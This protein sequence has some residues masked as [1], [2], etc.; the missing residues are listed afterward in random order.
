MYI[1][2]MSSLLNNTSQN[3]DSVELLYQQSESIFGTAGAL[4]YKNNW[5]IFPQEVEGRRPGNVLG[6]II[7][8]AEEHDLKNKLPTLKNLKLWELHCST[9]NAAC[10]F[11]PASKNTFAI[12]IDVLDENMSNEIAG[13]ADEILGY[14]PFRREGRVPKIA[15][16][17]RRP[18]GDE[19]RIPSTS[20]FFSK[21]D[22][23][24]DSIKSENGLEIL[25]DGKLL[26]FYGK[27]H[28]TGQYFK[29]LDKSPL[30]YG[31]EE[32]PIVT[33]EQVKDFLELVDATYRFHRGASF[34]AAAITWQ[35]DEES[36]MLVPEVSLAAG[37]TAWH[38]NIDGKVDDGREAYLSNLVYRTVLANLNELETAKKDDPNKSNAKSGLIF[39]YKKKIAIAV[40][41]SFETNVEMNSDWNRKLKDTAFYKVNS[42]VNKVIDGRLELKNE[43]SS[44]VNKVNITIPKTKKT[45]FEFEFF[46]KET[47]NLNIAASLSGQEEKEEDLQIPEDRSVLKNDIQMSLQVA[48]DDFFD[49]VYDIYRRRNGRVH[50]IKAPT[51]AGKTSQVIR[52]IANDP[53]TYQEVEYEDEKGNKKHERLPIVML[54]PTYNNID[55]LRQRAKNLNLNPNLSNED[56]KREALDLG[57]VLADEVD[58]KIEEIRRDALNCRELSYREANNKDGFVTMVYSGKIKAGCLVADKVSLAMSAGVGTSGFCKA[59]IPI[60]DESTKG[61]KNK[62]DE[63]IKFKEEI[64]PHYDYCPAIKQR[65]HIKDAHVVFMPHNF[66]SLS[67]PEEL[68][69][70]RAVIADERIHHLFL[71]STV[72]PKRILENS[73]RLPKLSKK[74]RDEG[75]DSKEFMND[76]AQAVDVVLSA[77]SNK[78]CPALALIDYVNEEELGTDPVRLRPGPS[79]VKS[80]IK[81]CSSAIERN[82]NLS[83]LLSIDEVK[84]LCEQPTGRFIREELTFWKLIEERI[85]FIQSDRLREEAIKNYEVDLILF[86]DQNRLD[87]II[88]TEDILNRIKNMTKKANG[89]FD[90]RIQLLLN[91]S[92]NGFSEEIIRISWRTEPNWLGTPL[93]LLDASAAPEVISKIWRRK[94]DEIVVHNIAEDIGKSLNVKIVAIVNQTFSNSSLLSNSSSTTFEKIMAAKNLVNVRKALTMISL[95]HSEGRVVAGTSI[96]LRGLINNGWSGPSNIDWCHFGAMRGLD[97]FKFHSAAFSV[98]RMEVPIRSID[99]LVAALTYDDLVPEYPYDKDGTGLDKEGKILRLPMGEQKI[100]LRTG[101]KLLLKIPQFPT[102]WGRLLQKQYREEELLQFVGRLRPVYREG[103]TP[104]W[105]ALS[106]VIPEELIVDKVVSIDN[107]LSQIPSKIIE[108]YRKTGGIL[109]I[110][111][112]LKLC[113]ELYK[114]E[115]SFVSALKSIGFNIK[116]GSK[117]GRFAKGF[118]I[119]KWNKIQSDESNYCFISNFIHNKI[120]YLKN[121]LEKN[122]FVSVEI[123]EIFDE[124]EFTLA[125]AKTFDKVDVTIGTLENRKILQEQRLLDIGKILLNETGPVIEAGDTRAYS[126][127]LK[128]IGNKLMTLS[129]FEAFITI[130]DYWN[131]S[132]GNINDNLLEFKTEKNT[133]I[134]KEDEEYVTYEE[135]EELLN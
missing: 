59:N 80:A 93:L 68:D 77:F 7:K 131:N 118:S 132:L 41:Q 112:V 121:E 10:V 87:D 61:S 133:D 74:E 115:K 96:A 106:S 76:R 75:Y 90:Y 94:E 108:A 88:K 55:E 51:G 72:F 116:D 135:M 62:K 27:H 34:S 78:I 105:Y 17:Y 114:N 11:G 60:I 1:N 101:H 35:W 46:K 89:D 102:K 81:V 83:P 3:T 37:G 38:E 69:N 43:K 65:N 99:G 73:R 31:P 39:D 57:L 103:R 107:L 92:V 42:L 79:W 47:N 134:I 48:Y 52:Y 45:D 124:K 18:E 130:N 127:K 120:E 64:C 95:L 23:N 4:L 2:N 21:L 25:G 56:L 14:S 6:D 123:E 63:K 40:T 71:H 44:R 129:E 109:D 85:N 111:L 16:I 128:D 26:T 9:L 97:M 66:L 91:P 100:R 125:R 19:N 122:L 117:E 104:V 5:S 33:P 110:P 30:V 119:F 15:L 8:W 84:S 22:E 32:A 126:I 24:G 28:K 70:V 82:G 12:D 54:L 53:R 20:R 86:R 50:I 13:M 58:D 67:L 113:P 98:G 29:W 36:K 49:D